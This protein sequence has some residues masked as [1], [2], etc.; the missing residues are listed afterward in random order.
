MDPLEYVDALHN[1]RYKNIQENS[2]EQY[3]KEEVLN[4]LNDISLDFK[5]AIYNGEYIFDIES[6]DNSS[7]K[8]NDTEFSVQKLVTHDDK[9]LL[10]VQITDILDDSFGE[11]DIQIL[12]EEISKAVKKT[13]NI[14]GV[15]ILPPNMNTTLITAK[16]NAL[17]KD[18]SN[19][20]QFDLDTLDTYDILH[21]Y[22]NKSFKIKKDDIS[23]K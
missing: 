22:I 2:K 20:L 23:D 5:K 7:V 19:V 14:A 10:F 18:F 9:Y 11:S 3:T 15:M 6:L 12:A 16:L 1:M 4:M 17:P 13:D 8:I 21:D